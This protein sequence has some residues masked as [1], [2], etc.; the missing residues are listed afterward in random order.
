M[1]APPAVSIVETWVRRRQAR[2]LTRV[3]AG[4]LLL[5]ARV[6]M[7]QPA[8]P[9][10]E[11]PVEVAAGFFL[12]NLSGVAER[13]ETFDADVY[14]SFRWRDSRLAF[15]GSE[16]KRYLEDQAAARLGEIWWPQL[17]F[18]NTKAATYTN[19]SLTIAPD[20]TVDYVVAVTSE[21]RTNLDLRRFPL[22]RQ[23]LTVSVESFTWTED[24][25]VFVPDR[26]RMGF[27][28][29][30]TFEGLVVNGVDA[31]VQPREVV[32]WGERYSNLVAT[33]DVRRQAAFYVWTVF[34]PVTLIFLIS[35]T[36][37]VVHIRNFQDRV[38][39]SLAALLACIATQFAISFSMPQIPYLTIV[40]RVFLVT[41]FCIAIGVLI[42]TIQAS[43]LGGETERAL[44]VDRWAGLGLPGLYLALI[45]VC[46]LW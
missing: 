22:D 27:N 23:T 3:A 45:A 25:M 30:S 32:G 38:A 36:V 5:L 9:P 2:C 42:S 15:E 40:D 34:V 43:V 39:I 1:L 19:R 20:G 33:I 7:G 21:F 31:H 8:L 37:F 26:T 24:Q 29:D 44:R 12:V 4:A 28:P 11:R 35:C 17:E 10:G 46:V 18:V 41:Y 14:L 6:A 13:S 16:P